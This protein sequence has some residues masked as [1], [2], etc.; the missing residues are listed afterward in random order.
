MVEME[1]LSTAVSVD[2]EVQLYLKP[3]NLQHLG[4]CG[5]NIPANR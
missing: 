5:E 2:K 3:K 1:F 4:R